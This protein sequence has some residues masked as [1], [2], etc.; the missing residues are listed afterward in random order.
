M[1]KKEPFK[2]DSNPKKVVIWG[3]SGFALVIADIIR[4]RKE[5]VLAGYLDD[6]NP[7]RKGEQFA[8]ST[9]LGG[10]EQLEQ[11]AGAGVKNIILG[12]GDC[13][14]RLKLGS[15]LKQLEFSLASALHPNAVIAQDAWLGEGL[16][17]GAGT[18]IDPLVTIGNYC[19]VNRARW[20]AMKV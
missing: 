13:K 17:V 11:L 14:G 9:V 3:A 10:R 2:R 1:I 20:S 16:M 5:L 19:I 7:Q 15:F 12:F 4:M 8:G 18:V 6:I